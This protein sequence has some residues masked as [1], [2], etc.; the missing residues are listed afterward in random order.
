[1]VLATQ[2]E[3]K[4]LH[5]TRVNEGKASQNVRDVRLSMD[6]LKQETEWSDIAAGILR[7]P[8]KILLYKSDAS[9]NATRPQGVPTVPKVTNGVAV[10]VK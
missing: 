6:L 4:R 5:Q 7:F 9:G 1:M 10:E 8:K 3:F 2:R